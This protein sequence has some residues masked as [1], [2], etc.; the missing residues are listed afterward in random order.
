MALAHKVRV[1]MENY[2]YDVFSRL[3]PTGTNTKFYKTFFSKMT[4][5]EFDAFFKEFFSD[6]KAYL[7]LNIELYQN[8]PTM[9]SI[10]KTAKFMCVPLYEY[11]VQPYFSRDKNHPMVT[12]YPVPV[13]YIHEKRVQQTAMK[14]NTTS[15]DISMRD[16]KLNQVIG[17]DK[18]ARQSIDENYALMALGAKKASKEFMSFRADD[19]IMKEQAYERIRQFGYVSMEDLPDK[20]ENKDSVNMLDAYLIGMGIKSDL[21]TDGYTVTKTTMD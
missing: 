19:G 16:A 14:K 1:K 2:I 21:I 10:E 13:G 6:K 4:D 17:A 3:D 15:I 7:V 20:V 18:N 8:E 11:V 12:R 5:K 9:E